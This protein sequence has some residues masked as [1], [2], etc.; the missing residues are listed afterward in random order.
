MGDNS[1]LTLLD[2]SAL[3]RFSLIGIAFP[4]ASLLNPDFFSKNCV[5]VPNDQ[6]L[7]HYSTVKIL[8][9]INNNCNLQTD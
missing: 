9:A 8:I 3:D 2:K 7:T 4:F 5:C 1:N 6:L